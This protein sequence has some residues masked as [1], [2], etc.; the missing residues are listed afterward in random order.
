M[1][2]DDKFI[3]PKWWLYVILGIF[4]FLVGRLVIID[5][6]LHDVFIIG[7]AIVF[8]LGVAKGIRSLSKKK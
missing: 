4:S 1:K 3:S 7:G 6:L 8:I 2:N 5:G